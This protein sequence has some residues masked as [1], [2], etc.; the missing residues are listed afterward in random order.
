MQAVVVEYIIRDKDD[1]EIERGEIRTG[2][3]L[4]LAR[5]ILRGLLILKTIK[6]GL[7]RVRGVAWFGAATAWV[8]SV[9]TGSNL[10]VTAAVILSIIYMSG[11]TLKQKEAQ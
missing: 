7:I 4:L 9:V 2:W 1:N 11:M 10:F 6:Q 8:V 5:S 3:R